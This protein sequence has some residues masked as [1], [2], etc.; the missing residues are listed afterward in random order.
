MPR[1]KEYKRYFAQKE[2]V[3]SFGCKVITKKEDYDF[4]SIEFECDK[5]HVCELKITTLKNSANKVRAG[6]ITSICG[7]CLRS[8]TRKDRDKQIKKKLESLSLKFIFRDPKDRYV[9]YICSCGEERETHETNIMKESKTPYCSDCVEDYRKKKDFKEME[10]FFEDNDCYLLTDE[11]NYVNNKQKLKYVCECGNIAF[12]TFANFKKGG[13]CRDCK[14]ERTIETCLREYG[15]VNMLQTEEAK[16]NSKLACQEPDVQ[17]KREQTMLN[18]HGMRFAFLTEEAKKR[19]EKS[20]M[21]RWGTVWP[22]Q[23]KKYWDEYAIPL[24]IKKYGSK[25]Y[26]QSEAYIE[27]M[28]ELYGVRNPLQDP[29]IHKKKHQSSFAYKE[30]ELP[31]GKVVNIMGYEGLC[32]DILLGKE[33][34]SFVDKVYKEDDLYFDEDVP[35]VDYIDNEGKTRVYHPDVL[36]TTATEST[37]IEVKSTFTFNVDS[38][39]MHEKAIAAAKMFNLQIW[40]FDGRKKL[41]L[42]I[43]Y[44]KEGHAVTHHG[45][46]YVGQKLKLKQGDDDPSEEEVFYLLKDDYIKYEERTLNAS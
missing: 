18:K 11:C 40:V 17:K 3:E 31:S 5:G 39:K 14:L 42:I 26:L 12:I 9:K 13:R 35:R 22:F 44:D 19:R 23:S 34:V 24:A 4:N 45:K 37:F 25:Y 28:M 10:K 30:Y 29:K 41:V 27:K 36:I 43:K 15:V 1:P 8:D 16:E 7:E 46:K 6:K 38:K 32:V 21:E 33:N 2:K 20:S